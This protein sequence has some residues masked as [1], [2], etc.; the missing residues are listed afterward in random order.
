MVVTLGHNYN[1]SY[2]FYNAN[3]RSFNDMA[4]P[5][6]INLSTVYC[7][8]SW[9]PTLHYVIHRAFQC[10]GQL[11]ARLS[12][13]KCIPLWRGRVEAHRHQ[14]RTLQH[15]QCPIPSGVFGIYLLSD[16]QLGEVAHHQHRLAYAGLCR[17]IFQ[18]PVAHRT[19]GKKS[20]AVFE[21]I[22]FVF[23]EHK[24]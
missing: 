24:H 13:V 6:V 23:V 12:R 15:H 18:Q 5:I 3:I 8:L 16:K 22:G 4:K 19:S 11:L 20:V 21:N 2:Y 9:P 10:L 17:K 7:W 1:I 14:P